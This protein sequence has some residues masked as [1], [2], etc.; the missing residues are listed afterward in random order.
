MSILH[1]Q[2]IIIHIKYRENIRPE[3]MIGYLQADD[4]P[5]IAKYW[6]VIGIHSYLVMNHLYNSVKH[7]EILRCTKN[8]G[9]EIII[10]KPPKILA[11]VGIHR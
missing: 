4:K 9:G 10:R 5:L 1:G 7:S 8:L 11:S 2:R 6:H 3:K